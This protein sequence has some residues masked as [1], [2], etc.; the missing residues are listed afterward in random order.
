MIIDFRYHIASLVAVFLAL[1]VGILI[2][3]AILGNT[4]LQRELGQIEENLD[5]KSVV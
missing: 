3:G 5:R 4:T 1:G 2:G